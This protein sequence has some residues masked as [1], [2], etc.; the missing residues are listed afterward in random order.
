MEEIGWNINLQKS[1]KIKIPPFYGISTS[2]LTRKSTGV[3]VKTCLPYEGNWWKHKPPKVI[4]NKNANISRDFDIH[5]E[6]KIQANRPDIVVKN[7]NNKTG[8]CLIESM[9]STP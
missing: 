1:L 4:E 2:T 6:R 3:Y 5:I 7:H 9:Q 8:P